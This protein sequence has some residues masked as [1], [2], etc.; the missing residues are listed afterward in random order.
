MRKLLYFPLKGIKGTFGAKKFWQLEI[1]FICSRSALIL[2][3]YK[4]KYKEKYEEKYE[5][6]YEEKY[7]EKYGE[8]MRKNMSEKYEKK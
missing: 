5:G 8:N 7:G 1:W 6:K 2:R 3:K 4:E